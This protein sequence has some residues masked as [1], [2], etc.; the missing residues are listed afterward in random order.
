[1]R[2]ALFGDHAKAEPV[3]RRLAE[4]GFEATIDDRPGL[5]KLWFVSQRT[6]PVRIEV[7]CK[8]VEK[9]ERFLLDLDE[10]EGALNQAIRCPECHSLRIEY[11]QYAKHSLLT[12][13]AFGLLAQLGM[14]EKDYYCED[15]HFEWPK[16]GTRARRSR[17]NLAP[18]YF[19][20]GIEQTTLSERSAKRPKAPEE[21]RKAA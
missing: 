10:R 4:E 18:F 19:I 3:W 17:P 5:T 6:T 21:Q 13:L 2:V 11:P 14:V 9:A 20:E 15:C 12:N 7:P 1:M 16:E 8:Q